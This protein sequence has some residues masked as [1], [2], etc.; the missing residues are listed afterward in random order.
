[1]KADIHW[2]D[3]CRVCNEHGLYT[4]GTSEQYQEM[5][6]TP[7]VGATLSVNQLMELVDTLAHDI[8]LHS[9]EGHEWEGIANLLAKEATYVF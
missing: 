3:I 6:D 8:A 4:C 9:E 7:G 1:M 5:L 2:S